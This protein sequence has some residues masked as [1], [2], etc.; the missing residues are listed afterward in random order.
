M[1]ERPQGRGA[2]SAAWLVR[3]CRVRLVPWVVLG[4]L[5][6]GQAA[7]YAPED[8][9]RMTFYAAKV[10]SRC[11]EGSPVPAP[12][13]LQVRFIANSNMGLANTNAFVRFF[14]WSYFDVADQDDRDVLWLISTRFLDHFEEVAEEVEESS[15]PSDRY[16][17][18]GRI[19][20]YIQLVS[21][22][23][24]ALPVYSARWWRWSFG[25]RFDGY[26]L[27]TD[28]L[29]GALELTGCDFLNPPPQSYRAV[30]FDLAQDTLR[31]VRSPIG[32][33]PTTWTSFWE[34]GEEPGDFG[35]Y[36]PAG[37]SFGRK[38][39][40]PCSEAREARCVLLED[41]PL[42][43]EF[44]LARQLAAVLATARAIYLH[45]VDHPESEASDTLPGAD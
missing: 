38:V 19:V 7:G 9:Q 22:P 16:Q 21:S 26:P 8:H 37:N 43:E 1:P 2:A 42:Y 6:S 20:G 3:S 44:A 36:G 11:L 4:A 27:L 13:P 40:F 35:E 24:R 23:S 45:Q 28:S 25:D 5:L 30:L 29:E 17:E 31:A 34:P 10:L 18:L 14:R 15:N 41:D 32:G 33:L 39:E 12:T